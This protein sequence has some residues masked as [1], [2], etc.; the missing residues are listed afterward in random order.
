MLKIGIPKEIMP[1][2]GRVALTPD[3]CR[4]LV[5][6]GCELHLQSKAGL[7]CGYADT[8][9]TAVGVTLHNTAEQLYR[10]GELI[11]KVKQPLVEDLKLLDSRHLLFSFLHLAADFCPKNFLIVSSV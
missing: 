1:G 9:Y 5:K 11:V 6:S 4:H 8:A 2:E 3:D 10:A 7:A